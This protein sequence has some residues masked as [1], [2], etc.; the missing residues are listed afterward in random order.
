MVVTVANKIILQQLECGRIDGLPGYN[1]VTVVR[2]QFV[3]DYVLYVG[4]Q[5]FFK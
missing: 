4:Y 1:S 3:P 5:D 2:P